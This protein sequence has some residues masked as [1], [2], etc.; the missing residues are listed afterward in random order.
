MVEND[1]DD[2]DDDEDYSRS[3]GG[4]ANQRNARNKRARIGDSDGDAG[5]QQS[6]SAGTKRADNFESGSEEEFIPGLTLKQAP[7]T[8]T[9]GAAKPNQ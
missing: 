4:K 8:A 3:A 2:D 5:E 1:D 6:K 7:A 9:D